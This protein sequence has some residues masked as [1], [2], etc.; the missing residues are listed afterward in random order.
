LGHGVNKTNH[1]TLCEIVGL[2]APE[3]IKQSTQQWCVCGIVTACLQLVKFQILHYDIIMVADAAVMKV[4]LCLTTYCAVCLAFI[5][6]RIAFSHDI[7]CG[8]SDCLSVT[9]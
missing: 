7:C 1:N 8:H 4:P 6:H 3:A 5:V 9:H 2:I